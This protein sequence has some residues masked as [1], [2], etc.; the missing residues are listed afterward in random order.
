MVTPLTPDAWRWILFATTSF[1]LTLPLQDLR[2]AEG[3]RRSGRTWLSMTV[4]DPAARAILVGL[5]ALQPV[6]MQLL[7]V[8]PLHRGWKGAACEAI[9]ALVN[10]VTAARC[11]ALRDPQADRRPRGEHARPPLVGTGCRRA[12]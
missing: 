11:G 2:D 10:L 3:D 5:L 8:A 6:A 12:R 4:G 7:L 1:G 9:L